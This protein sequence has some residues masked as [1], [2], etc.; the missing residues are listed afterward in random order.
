M[1][2]SRVVYGAEASDYTGL[3]ALT[4]GCNNRTNLVNGFARLCT[5]VPSGSA[6]GEGRVM[7]LVRGGPSALSAGALCAL[8]WRETI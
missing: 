2:G 4:L 3:V 7:N 1:Q 5:M 8:N 6:Q